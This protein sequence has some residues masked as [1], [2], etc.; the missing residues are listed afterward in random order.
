[1]VKVWNKPESAFISA[2]LAYS[3]YVTTFCAM[4]CRFSTWKCVMPTFLVGLITTFN[5]TCYAQLECVVI[6]LPKIV[7]R[8]EH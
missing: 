7:V 8:P 6:R 2:C 4:F 1:M 3:G 5:L